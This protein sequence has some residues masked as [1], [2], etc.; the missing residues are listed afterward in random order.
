MRDFL[1]CILFIGAVIHFI[2]KNKE[3]MSKLTIS[4]K[5]AMVLT[6][7]EGIAVCAFGIMY[8][9]RIL[10]EPFQ[11]IIVITFIRILVVLFGLTVCLYGINRLLLRI[12][13]GVFPEA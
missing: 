7:A 3:K 12:T 13:K 10:T 6:Y 11:N 2:Y 8:G 1:M 4:Q 5:A 9:G